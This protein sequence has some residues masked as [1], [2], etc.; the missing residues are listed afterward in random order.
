MTILQKMEQYRAANSLH[1]C[2]VLIHVN[3]NPCNFPSVISYEGFHLYI[4]E[5]L[6][7]HPWFICL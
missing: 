2:M 5:I 7:Q 3:E 4:L 1:F 6:F